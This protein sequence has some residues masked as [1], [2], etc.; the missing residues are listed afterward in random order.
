MI[1]LK[2]VSKDVAFELVVLVTSGADIAVDLASASEVIFVAVAALVSAEVAVVQST[3]ARFFYVDD[4]VA[5]V[6]I[7]ARISAA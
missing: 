2:F 5:L 3:L 1:G 6:Y 7:V 4:R